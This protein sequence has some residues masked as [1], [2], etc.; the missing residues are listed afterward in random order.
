MRMT[1]IG[2]RW[3]LWIQWE[4]EEGEGQEY[5]DPMTFLHKSCVTYVAMSNK[6]LPRGGFELDET[7]LE[8]Q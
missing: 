7:T 3:C 4:M 1:T 5:K 2:P 8:V 6:V